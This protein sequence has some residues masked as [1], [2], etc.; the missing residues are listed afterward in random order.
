MSGLAMR[1]TWRISSENG[2]F[3][4]K[5]EVYSDQTR[6][7][8]MNSAQLGAGFHWEVDAFSEA[9]IA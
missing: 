2:N 8:Q 4:T 3:L 7:R 9:R 1:T 5:A 6:F